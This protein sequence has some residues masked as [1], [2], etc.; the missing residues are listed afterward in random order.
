MLLREAVPGDADL[1]AD[2]V[3][4]AV[5]W[6]G[7]AIALDRGR[8]LGD[9]HLRRYVEDWPRAGDAGLVAVDDAGA[10]LGAA[11]LRTFRAARPGYG[12]VA[13]D[14]PELSMAVLEGARGSGAGSALLDG[15]LR[16]ARAHGWRAVSLSV[17]DGNAL[18]RS[19]YGRRGFVPVGRE[20]GSD[21]LLLPLD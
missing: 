9:D 11:W 18:A 5:D 8:V 14:V 2:L 4:A 3:V 13:E 12:F 21:V 20:G 10:P 7:A 15:C 16:L 6:T 17:E 19:M 1:L